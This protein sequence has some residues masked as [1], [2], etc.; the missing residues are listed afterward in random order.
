MAMAMPPSVIVLIVAPNAFRVSAA[1][2]SDSGIARR[3]MRLARRF[4]RN[5]S[6]VTTTRM[7]PSRSASSTFRTATAMKSA[8]RKIRRSIV[9]PSGSVARISSS[10]ASKAFVRA[11]VLAPGCFWMPRMTAGFAR[12]DPSPRLIASPIRTSPR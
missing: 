10:V 11:S 5:R 9:I 3:V 7:P 1:V 12:A 2:T 8:W 6:T 4:P